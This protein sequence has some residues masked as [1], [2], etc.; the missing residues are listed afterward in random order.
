MLW[1]EIFLT[2]STCGTYTTRLIFVA[3]THQA[4]LLRFSQINIKYNV[5]TILSTFQVKSL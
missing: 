5:L 4:L 3:L 1:K 2:S